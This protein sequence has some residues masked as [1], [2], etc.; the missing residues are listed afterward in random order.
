MHQSDYVRT[1]AIARSLG[2]PNSMIENRLQG[3][4]IQFVS[5]RNNF[6]FNVGQQVR[7]KAT[8]RIDLV[9]E[10]GFDGDAHIYRLESGAI[11][12]QS[13]LEPVNAN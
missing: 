10:R 5:H 1:K 2:L 11:E 4:R 3:S 12:Y 8:G 6:D 7:V 13:E 9:T